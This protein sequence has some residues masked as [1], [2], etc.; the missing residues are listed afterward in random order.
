MEIIECVFAGAAFEDA[1]VAGQRSG[2]GLKKCR[3][4]ET[5]M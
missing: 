3:D 4:L 5:Y 2:L 1:A